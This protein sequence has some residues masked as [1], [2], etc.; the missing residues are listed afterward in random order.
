MPSE[1]RGPILLL[2]G[3]AEARVLSQAIAVAG[4]PAITSLAGVTSKPEIYGGTVRRGGF[5][6]VDGLAA[7][8]RSNDIRAVIDATHPFAEQISTNAARAAGLT[9]L[10]IARLSRPPWKSGPGDFWRSTNDLAAAIAMLPSGAHGFIAAGASAA[11]GIS[12]REDIQLTLRAIEPPELSPG[13]AV[14]VILSRPPYPEMAERALFSKLKITHL[15]CKNAGGDSGRGK[16]NAARALGLPVFMI[17]QPTLVSVD[18]ELADIK[19]ALHWI[20]ALN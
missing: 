15:I 10:P 3:T 19:S 7:F 13:L 12:L 17:P 18:R 14:T 5:G 16:L 6:G 8:L 9:G 11:D 2:G 4:I 20:A 1:R